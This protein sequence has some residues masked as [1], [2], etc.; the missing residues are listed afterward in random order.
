MVAS[1]FYP[2]LRESLIHPMLDGLFAATKRGEIPPEALGETAAKICSYEKWVPLI[3]QFEGNGRQIFDLHDRLTELLAHTDVK[4]ATLSDLHTPYEAFFVRFGL[5][6]QI[7]LPF[8]EAAGTFEYVDGA[9]VAYAPWDETGAKRLKVGF[10]TVH[11]DGR[12]VGYPGMFFDLL[13]HELQ[14]AVPE[15]IEASM[16]RRLQ[17]DADDPSDD[18]NSRALKSYLRADI[19]DSAVLMR[20]CSALLFNCLFYLES[21]EHHLP[22]PSPGRDTPPDRV[23]KWMNSPAKRYKLNSALT[24]DGFAVVRLVGGEVDGPPAQASGGI[25]GGVRVHWRRG[26]WRMQPY[27]QQRASRRRIWIK[28]IL[29]GSDLASGPDASHGHIYVPPDVSNRVQ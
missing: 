19:E 25:G 1:N 3:A 23:A 12:Q 5:Q 20:H 2:H 26:H 28:P 15:A 21:I 24:S 18:D 11:S 13:P 29:V 16:K 9:Y 22:E 4:D 17:D 8:D 27:G 14:M 6:E 10:A 7:R